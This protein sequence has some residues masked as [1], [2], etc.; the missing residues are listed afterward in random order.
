MSFSRLAVAGA[1]SLRRTL[2]DLARCLADR[3]FLRISRSVIVNRERIRGL[4]R[5]KKG[6]YAVELQG[7]ASL[8]LTRSYHSQLDGLL[9]DPL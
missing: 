2:S 7:G 8:K 3:G 4:A 9:G 5:L 1:Y 6:E